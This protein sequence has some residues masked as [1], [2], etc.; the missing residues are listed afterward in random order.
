M[1][2]QAV[3]PV[4]LLLDLAWLVCGSWRYQR[5]ELPLAGLLAQ[6]CNISDLW[7]LKQE[8]ARLQQA[9]ELSLADTDR[10]EAGTDW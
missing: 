1:P 6:C 5:R 10:S 7:A 8:H 4:A 9:T 2:A 3:G